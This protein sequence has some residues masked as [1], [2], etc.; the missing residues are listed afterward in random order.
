[1]SLKDNRSWK[2]E[3]RAWASIEKP[4][5]ANC[6]CVPMYA[7]RG[8]KAHPHL[9]QELLALECSY[10]RDAKK[11]CWV[12][13]TLCGIPGDGVAE[14]VGKNVGV[15]AKGA[16]REVKSGA[17]H[18][19]GEWWRGAWCWHEP[20]SWGRNIPQPWLDPAP[21]GPCYPARMGCFK[22]WAGGEGSLRAPHGLLE[23]QST[24]CEVRVL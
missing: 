16:V 18:G 3:D 4:G 17:G 6:L 10:E 1:M 5:P 22:P 14:A 9:Q 21:T 15:L 23:E 13:S 11:V 20:G 12:V 24:R 8:G 7:G 19:W 2:L